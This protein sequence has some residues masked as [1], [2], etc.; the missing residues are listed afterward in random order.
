M[1]YEDI[2][3]GMT[4][5]VEGL[6]KRTFAV[7]AYDETLD[8]VLLIDRRGAVSSAPASIITQRTF[9]YVEE[10]EA[11]HR[12]AALTAKD[13]ERFNAMLNKL[14]VKCLQGR[15]QAYA[16]Y[17][18]SYLSEHTGIF[19]SYASDEFIV[20]KVS[21]ISYVL[22]NL[23]INHPSQSEENNYLTKEEVDWILRHITDKYDQYLISSDADR[24]DVYYAALDLLDRC[25][26]GEKVM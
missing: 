18:M 21:D 22:V 13:P 7:T 15:E 12:Y 25:R 6:G 1:R 20:E 2:K 14:S 3:I 26:I 16:M 10:F 23:E 4:C 11:K 24:S 9:S 19:D 17:I 5:T 8:I